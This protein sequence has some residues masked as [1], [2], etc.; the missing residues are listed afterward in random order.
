[1]FINSSI[2]VKFDEIK[3]SVN[4]KTQKAVINTRDT[5]FDLTKLSFIM[6]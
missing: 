2:V 5:A 6:D 1:M 4:M 3:V